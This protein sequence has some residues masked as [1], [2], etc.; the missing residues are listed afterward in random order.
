MPHISGAFPFGRGA[1]Q[2]TYALFSGAWVAE[3]PAWGEAPVVTVLFSGSGS[4]FSSPLC[5]GSAWSRLNGTGRF[6]GLTGANFFVGAF[7]WSGMPTV[8]GGGSGAAGGLGVARAGGTTGRTGVNR[9]VGG[10][11]TA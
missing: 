5:V 3:P 6:G 1:G 9:R 4:A 8:P 10:S 11:A 7:R 2:E